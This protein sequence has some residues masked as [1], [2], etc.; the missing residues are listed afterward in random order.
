MQ[1]DGFSTFLYR[2]AEFHLVLR[3]VLRLR[4]ARNN[5]FFF[6]LC[7]RDEGLAGNQR[8]QVLHLGR[9]GGKTCLQNLL[10]DRIDKKNKMNALLLQVRCPCSF[11]SSCKQKKC[12]RCVGKKI[13]NM[14]ENN[15]EKIQR[16]RKR[17]NS[18][19]R[20]EEMTKGILIFEQAG[21]ELCAF[22][23]LR[24]DNTYYTSL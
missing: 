13:T 11:G 19:E 6:F 10:I 4:K 18:S 22:N 9:I 3:L 5:F 15:S 23:V 16:G 1:F 17:E 24:R 21:S 12:Y 14:I 8:S 2:L 7:P 20:I